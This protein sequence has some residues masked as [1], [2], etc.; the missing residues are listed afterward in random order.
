MLKNFFTS[1]IANPC[2][3]IANQY[4]PHTQPL[5]L[6]LAIWP[7]LR[8]FQKTQTGNRMKPDETWEAV[9]TTGIDY[10]AELVCDR[11]RDADIPAVVMNKRDHAISVNMGDLAQIK[12]MVPADRLH[13]AKSLLSEQVLSDRELTEAA[14]AAN[15]FGEE[16]PDVDEDEEDG[17]DG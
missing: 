8:I 5:L 12:V 15:P 6:P 3:L 1:L 11:L 14:L 4:Y 13:A 9:Y 7:I 16:A 2:S 10:D 17:D